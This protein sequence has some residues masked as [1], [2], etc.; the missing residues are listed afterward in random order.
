MRSVTFYYDLV[1]PY[2][3]LASTQIEAVAAR[4]GATV[5]WV[6]VLLGGIFR[7]IGQADVPAA[8]M[9]APKQQL[10]RL[11]MRRWAD[12]YG[13]PLRLHPRHPLRTVEAM[14]LCH[15]VDGAERVALT[16][17]L[18]RAHF[19]ENRDISERAVLAE[20][21]DV[22]ALDRPEVKERLRAATERAVADGAFGVPTFV[23]EQ[24]GRRFAFWGQDRLLFVDKALGGWEIPA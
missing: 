14:R 9:P 23:V 10:N 19:A 16:H 11:D 22:A 4:A 24:R 5:E 13:V 6:P 17:R 20:Y 2:A 3:Y 1:C 18:Y 7:A 15:S 12:V 21:G 8:Q